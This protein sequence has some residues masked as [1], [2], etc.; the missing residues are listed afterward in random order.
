MMIKD[1][2]SVFKQT[3][4]FRDLNEDVLRV[5]ASRA[6]EKILQRDEIL[7]LAGD[8]AAGLFVIATGALRA[9]R[10][11]QDGREQIIHIERAVSTIAELPVFD[12]GKYPSTTAAEEDSTKVYFLDK[13]EVRAV[14]LKHPEVA[15]AAT[16]LLAARLRH[17]AELVES[18]SLREVGQRLACLLLAEAETKGRQS[19]KGIRVK[20]KLT[21]R[22]L[23]S[24]IGT[25]REVITRVFY[26][27]Q[28]LGLIAVD[29]KEIF[30]PDLAA[31][32]AYA[33]SDKN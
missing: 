11:G 14:C 32:A 27:L 22:Q 16:R 20:Q 30:I 18:L 12:D 17:C 10:T 21:H 3:E 31:L 6:T 15:L 24:R 19:D 4:L 1:K 9:F 5:L 23:A 26:R 13:K 2:V 33:D 8:E 29:G 25:V 28:S 7:F